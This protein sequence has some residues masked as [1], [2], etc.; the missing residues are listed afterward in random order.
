L[1][2]HYNEGHAEQGLTALAGIPLW[3][4][5]FRSLDLRRSVERNISVEQRQRGLEEAGYVFMK[6]SHTALS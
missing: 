1:G 3:L 4:H 6:L 5:A 2:F